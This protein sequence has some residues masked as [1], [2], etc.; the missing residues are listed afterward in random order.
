MILRKRVPVTRITS[1]SDSSEDADR[2][3][4]SPTHEWKES[5]LGWMSSSTASFGVVPTSQVIRGSSTRHAHEGVTVPCRLGT[6]SSDEKEI[7]S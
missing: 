4:P 2:S 3:V 7:P 1:L 6:P 5:G